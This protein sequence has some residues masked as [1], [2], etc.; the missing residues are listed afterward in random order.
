MSEQKT[1][2]EVLAPWATCCERYCDTFDRGNPDCEDCV[3]R[4][5]Y[6]RSA[7]L[8]HLAS[9]QVVEAVAKALGDNADTPRC[10]T[11]WDTLAR[12]A[13]TAQREVLGGEGE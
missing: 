4:V 6:A 3:E 13:L 7:V 10:Y 11:G 9:E 1:L 12:A 2:G 8:A 5:A